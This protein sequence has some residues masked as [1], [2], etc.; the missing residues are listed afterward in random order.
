MVLLN[1][2]RILEVARA[3]IEQHGYEQLSLRRLARSLDVTAPALYDHV[4][5]KGALLR[6]LADEG[7]EELASATASNGGTPIERVRERSLAYVR[8]ARQHAELFRLMFT[9]RPDAV[10]ID[11]DNVL[12]GASRAWDVAVADV[13]RAIVDGDLA[14]RDPLQVAMTLWVAMHG[15]A[16]I[17]TIAPDVAEGVA[18]NVIDTLLV[19]LRPDAAL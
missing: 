1:R 2:D 18:A 9:Y 13:R 17:A 12:P 5:S 16:T 19:G 3:T 11:V 7:F 6:L 10:D 14:D 8:F 15:V 4:D